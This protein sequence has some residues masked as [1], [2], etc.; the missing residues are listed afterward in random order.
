MLRVSPGSSTQVRG[1][2]RVGLQS[3]WK[4]GCLPSR[5]PPKRRVHQGKAETRPLFPAAEPLGAELSASLRRQSCQTCRG[6]TAGTSPLPEAGEAGSIGHS[7]SGPARAGN[8][9]QRK[10][11]PEPPEAPALGSPVT[12]WP[13]QR[14]RPWAP[15]RSHAGSPGVGAAVASGRCR[16]RVTSLTPALCLP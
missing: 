1:D 14:Q 12:E 15:P 16:S 4:L 9:V 7:R 10:A 13:R 3:R 11:A 5:I 2:R 6:S 8:G